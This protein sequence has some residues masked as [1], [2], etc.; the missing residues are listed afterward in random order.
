MTHAEDGEADFTVWQGFRPLCWA[1]FCHYK[2][3]V[4][5]QPL[6]LCMQI[7]TACFC[8]QYWHPKSAVKQQTSVL[9]AVQ[10]GHVTQ[11]TEFHYTP[12]TQRFDVVIT[13]IWIAKLC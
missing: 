6:Y 10:P 2:W 1:Q 7:A 13:A 11:P 3:F 5:M 12:V 4:P 8:G 9:N